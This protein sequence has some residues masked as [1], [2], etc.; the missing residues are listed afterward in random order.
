ML[1]TIRSML[2]CSRCVIRIS[3]VSGSLS[4]TSFNDHNSDLYQFDLDACLQLTERQKTEAL[5]VC[6][7]TKKSSS[8][9]VQIISR[10]W[11]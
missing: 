7:S 3:D 6:I 8:V 10:G 1:I 5:L 2:G 11:L 4:E 9:N